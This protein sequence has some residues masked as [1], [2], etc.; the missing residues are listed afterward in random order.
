[1][2]DRPA[3]ARCRTTLADGSV[4]TVTATR[5]PRDGR[6]DV[7]CPERMQHVVR[8]ARLTEARM[9]SRDQVVISIDRNPAPH[10][11]DWELAAVLADRMVRGVWQGVWQGVSHGGEAVHANG[12]SDHWQ[13]GRVDG[14]AHAA[15]GA[16]LGGAL[17][18]AHL[19]GLLGQPDCGASVASARAWFPLHS[20]GIHDSLCWV[21]VSVYPLAA[22]GGEEEDSIAAPGLDLA[23]QHAV[24]QALAGARH[25]DGRALGRWRTVVRFGQPRFQ[26]NSF[27]LALV[28]A[29]RLA[30]GR[31]FV[32]RGR[33]IAT[34]CSSAWHAGQVEPVDGCQP[35]CALIAR[36]AL[37]G[38][39]ILLPKAWEAGL[40]PAFLP[41]VRAAGASVACIDRI[42]II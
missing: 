40:A 28:M 9:D 35:K 34:G 32:P 11:R 33:V 38:D 19:G 42:G 2:S 3:S 7:K 23:A 12:W 5:R 36:E 37:A 21:E 13:L 29:D 18:L 39:R 8:L 1:M 30:R 20:G 4:A 27:E 14:H 17:G 6:A 15:P 22:P 10:E 31:E 26:G 25:F 16:I 41:A 24:R